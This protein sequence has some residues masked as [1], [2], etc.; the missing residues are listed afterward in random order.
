MSTFGFSQGIGITYQAVIYNPNGEELPGADNPYA[1]LTNEDICLKFSIIDT[2]GDIEYQEEVRV[3]TDAFGMVNL[4]IGI[5]TQTD[6][7]AI[8]FNGIVWN[9][10]AKFLKV[11]IDIDGGCIN[12][13]ELSNQPFTYVP[14]AYYSPASDIPGPQGLPGED[15]ATGPQGDA[16]PQGPQGEQGEQGEDGAVGATGPEGPQGPQG[17]QGEQGETG[18]IASGETAGNTPYW[19]GSQWVV[20]NSNIYNNGAGVGIGTSTP[21]ASAK[22][23][24]ATTTQGFLPPRL[25]TSERDAIA[26]PVD[27]LMIFNISTMCPNFYADSVW[28]EWCGTL[29]GVITSLN[30][31][32]ATNTG[33]LT[34]DTPASGVSSSVPYTGGNGGT[35]NGQ[36]ITS[37]GVTGLI[38]ILLAG[39][40]AN[41]AGT[42]TYNITG[43]PSAVGTASFTLNV[44]GQ[45]C[46]L[47]L[48]VNSG[49]TYPPDSVFCNDTPSAIVEVMNPTTGKIWM[50]RNLGATQVASSINDQNAYGDLYQ[51]GRRSDGHQCRDSNITNILSTTPQPDNGDFIICQECIIPPLPSSSNWHSPTVDNLWQG[52]NGVNNPCPNGYR[53]PTEAELNQE[54]LSWASNNKEGAFNSALKLPTAGVR[55]AT[56]FLIGMGESSVIW[57][58]TI[59]T[60]GSL[61]L[62]NNNTSA[63]Y[64]YFRT[65]GLSVRC[66]KD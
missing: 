6:G 39:T 4:L 53:I 52:V 63:I 32:S 65:V 17:P 49:V 45:T 37:T 27:G 20:N 58:S 35:H 15:G 62:G 56:G 36:T 11:D 47:D 23:E 21:N 14:F 61:Y 54:R 43:T 28:H 38:A 5:N 57:S 33:T 19:D 26:N 50:D 18:L 9:A 42:L 30:C 25:T 1:P 44:G 22:V 13:E 3:R 31:G 46:N 16:G 64:M 29:Q 40:F 66:L 24:I 51:W 41:G 12:F 10:D 8:G 59:D 48:T 2:N 55:N 60:N 34:I 7:Y